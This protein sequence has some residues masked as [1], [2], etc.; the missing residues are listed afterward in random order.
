MLYGLKNTV[1]LVSGSDKLKV[2]I[3]E[4]LPW[5]SQNSLECGS[6]WNDDKTVIIT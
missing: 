6:I 4:Q 5:S 2:R 1:L 3:V